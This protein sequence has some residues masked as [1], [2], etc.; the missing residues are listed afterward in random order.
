MILTISLGKFTEY[1]TNRMSMDSD[2]LISAKAVLQPYYRCDTDFANAVT[3]FKDALK[4]SH[5]IKTRNLWNLIGRLLDEPLDAVIRLERKELV[6]KLLLDFKLSTIGHT[7][8]RYRFNIKQSAS[9]DFSQGRLTIPADLVLDTK[10]KTKVLSVD[11]DTRTISHNMKLWYQN[12][13]FAIHSAKCANTLETTL[14]IIDT[15]QKFVPTRELH[16]NYTSLQ[17]YVKI[18]GS[19]SKYCKLCWRFSICETDY[20]EA[21]I[22]DTKH[23][24]KLNDQYCDYHNPGDS[25]SKY[26]SDLPYFRP[27]SI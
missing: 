17:S 25:T 22:T 5:N 15:L 1:S 24:F 11:I 7:K 4:L 6:Q 20:L 2:L 13:R 18:K 8:P 14:V 19:A 23:N 27:F 3:E 16:K 10:I 26:K 21:K 9:Q 12:V